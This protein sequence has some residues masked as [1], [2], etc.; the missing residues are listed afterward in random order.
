MFINGMILPLAQWA[1][2]KKKRLLSV[3][4]LC[5]NCNA[6]P[7]AFKFIDKVN[8]F[9]NAF[10]LQTQ[11]DLLDISDKKTLMSHINFQPAADTFSNKLEISDEMS[12]DDIYSILAS[13]L[14]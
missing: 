6:Y 7:T 9:R 1:R 13:K 8:M 3:P 10:F 4:P 2:G 12:Y 5:T 11:A 14:S